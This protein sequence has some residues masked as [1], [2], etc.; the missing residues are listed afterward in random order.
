MGIYQRPVQ[1]RH[2]SW[3]S[4]LVLVPTSPPVVS[5]GVVPLSLI[6]VVRL[7]IIDSQRIRAVLLVPNGRSLGL[8]IFLEIFWRHG[9][10]RVALQ[11]RCARICIHLRTFSARHPRRRVQTSHRAPTDR[12]SP[13]RC[14]AGLLGG[15]AK[16][17]C[18]WMQSPVHVNWRAARAH[19]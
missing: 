4:T 3:R 19:P 7:R 11:L 14:C 17:V 12:R 6:V 5:V 10:A 18:K 13:V 1:S 2:Q 8:A 9:W 16:S 15:Q